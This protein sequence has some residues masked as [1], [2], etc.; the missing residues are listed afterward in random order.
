MPNDV[1]AALAGGLPA[2]VMAPPAETRARLEGLAAAGELTL[3]QA[4]R[5]VAKVGGM[6]SMWLPACHVR[7]ICCLPLPACCSRPRSASAFH[8]PPHLA[9][10]SG[11]SH[12][13]VP[14]LWDRPVEA[15]VEKLRALA[16][17]LGC[18]QAAAAQLLAAQ[19][20][21]LSLNVP[22]MA[23]DRIE[24]LAAAL[25]VSR[26]RVRVRGS[27]YC[28]LQCM[29]QARTICQHAAARMRR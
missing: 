28:H 8:F 21:L 19:P 7:G 26:A 22:G 29:A 11:V 24:R 4:A 15:T 18:S 9:P 14:A 20:V 27:V 13:Q 3:P 16:A 6:C 2:A 17:E 25:A 10:L 12:T 1:L 23:A 5:L